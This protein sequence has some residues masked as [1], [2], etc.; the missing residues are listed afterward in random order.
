LKSG[1]HDA[2]LLQEKSETRDHETETHERE[3]GTNPR[4]ECALG[5]E[6]V[7]WVSILW[8]RW[9]HRRSHRGILPC[10]RGKIYC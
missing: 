4:E 9:W 7:G 6:I 8:R 5:G 2:N 3:A 10:G 1:F